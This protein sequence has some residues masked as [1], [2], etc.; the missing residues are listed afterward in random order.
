MRTVLLTISL[1]WATTIPLPYYAA[2]LATIPLPRAAT[3]LV[4]LPLLRTGARA[5]AAR[6]R[7]VRKIPRH[8]AQMSLLASVRSPPSLFRS[9]IPRIHPISL[10]PLPALRPQ[11]V[12][13]LI[14]IGPASRS[15]CVRITFQAATSMVQL[16]GSGRNVKCL[17]IAVVGGVPASAA[18]GKNVQLVVGV[19]RLLL[20]DERGPRQ[21][22]SIFG[23]VVVQARRPGPGLVLV[24]RPRPGPAVVVKQ[25]AAAAGTARCFS[26]R[27]SSAASRA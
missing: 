2:L 20:F 1:L 5:S 26:V 8:C 21:L 25:G 12:L 6:S 7:I 3:L 22:P 19:D 18:A 4:V 13:P 11:F 24:P 17:R 15:P 16:T 10:P 27:T 14:L 23:V 9:R